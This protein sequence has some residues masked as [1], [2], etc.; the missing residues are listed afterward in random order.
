MIAQKMERT[1]AALLPEIYL[2]VKC[3]D[4]VCAYLRTYILRLSRKEKNEV[5]WLQAKLSMALSFM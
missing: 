1:L 5:Y 3:A 4:L 2:K